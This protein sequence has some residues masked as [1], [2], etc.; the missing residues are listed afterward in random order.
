LPQATVDRIFRTIDTSQN[1]SLEYGEFCDFM[2][3]CT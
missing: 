3:K 1:G 2:A